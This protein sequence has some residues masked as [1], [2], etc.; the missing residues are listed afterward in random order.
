MAIAFDASSS[1]SFSG[2]GAA[3]KT[4][5]SVTVATGGVLFVIVG[6]NSTGTAATSDI[7]GV[8]YNG[9]AMTQAVPVA[10]TAWG[11]S[12]W[13]LLA[14]ATGAAHSVVVTSGSANVNQ[15]AISAQSYTGADTSS[16]PDSFGSNSAT[17]NGGTFAVSTTVVASNCWLIAG[18]ASADDGA[19]TANTHLTRRE[20][21]A[22]QFAS[23]DSNGTVGT[24]SQSVIWNQVGSGGKVVGTVISIRPFVAPTYT[25]PALELGHVF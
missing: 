21:P 4:L 22:Q 16:Q 3:S 11:S 5:S 15:L 2:V 19:P 25:F 1:T 6:W 23:G 24:G 17:N 7:T 8:T 20:L 9:V 10:S 12:I 14:P 13:Y 18:Y